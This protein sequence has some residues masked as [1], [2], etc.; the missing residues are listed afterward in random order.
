MF[1]HP[2]EHKQT[3][4]LRA[5]TDLVACKRLVAPVSIQPPPLV[6]KQMKVD[7]RNS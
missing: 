5:S 4:R 3:V 1:F 7:I 6:V 2:Q